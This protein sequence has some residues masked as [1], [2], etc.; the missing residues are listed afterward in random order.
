MNL[1]IFQFI[2]ASHVFKY[3]EYTAITSGAKHLHD[4][5]IK[6]IHSLRWLYLLSEIES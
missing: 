6:V 1:V 2:M 5:F 3:I 4:I